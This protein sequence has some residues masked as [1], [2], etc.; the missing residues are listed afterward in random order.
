MA[1]SLGGNR[2]LPSSAI[3]GFYQGRSWEILRDKPYAGYVILQGAIGDDRRVHNLKIVE[4][5]PDEARSELASTFAERVPITGVSVGSN[6]RPLAEVC[7]LFYE[8]DEIRRHALVYAE[9]TGIVGNVRSEGAEPPK[10]ML[11]T[12]YY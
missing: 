3:A 10:S 6:M 11:L 1:G 4:A 9:Q 12:M 5:Y 2:R 7:V 8:K